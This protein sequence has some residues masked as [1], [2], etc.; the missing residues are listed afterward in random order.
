MTSATFL[1]ALRRLFAVIFSLFMLAPLVVIM[2]LSFTGEG[3]TRFPPRAFGIRWYETA[4]NT[5][6]FIDAFKFSLVL[7]LLVAAISGLLGIVSALILG[8]TAFRGRDLIVNVIMMPLALPHIVLAIALLQLFSFFAVRTSPYGLLA[9]QILIT[10]PYVVRLVLTSLGSLNRQFELASQS[11]GAS[12]W[13][14]LTRVTLPLIAPGVM[15]GLLFAFLLSFDEVTIAIFMSQPGATTL[16]TEIF[17][18][19]SQGDD[20]VV[21]AVSG[22]LIVFAALFVALIERVFGVLRLIVNEEPRA[23]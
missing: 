11:L 22:F 2:I 21:T 6:A 15:G 5:P 13:Y 16:P 17:N 20:P 14:T 9:G 7:S 12:W 4:Y 3:Y 19:A 10:L 23:R 18:Y 8:R 1:H